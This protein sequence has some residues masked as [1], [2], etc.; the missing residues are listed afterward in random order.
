RSSLLKSNND[1]SESSGFID[2]E[3]WSNNDDN[4]EYDSINNYE[5]EPNINNTEST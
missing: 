4:V 3:P 1:N 5:S 2:L